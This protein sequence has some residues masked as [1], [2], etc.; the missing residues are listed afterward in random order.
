MIQNIIYNLLLSI[1]LITLGV[2]IFIK[3][4]HTPEKL[5]LLNLIFTTIF[6]NIFLFWIVFYFYH[7]YNNVTS[8]Q[9]HNI[10]NPTSITFGL[11]GFLIL[12]PIPYFFVANGILFFSYLLSKSKLL[13]LIH[14]LIFICSIYSIFI[15]LPK[16][17]NIYSYINLLFAYLWLFMAISFLRKFIK[18]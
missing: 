10:E 12:F 4:K 8:Y 17:I 7:C 9:L 2:F 1:P 13:L 5:N 15:I 18:S 11:G 6:I 16:N 14:L 3:N